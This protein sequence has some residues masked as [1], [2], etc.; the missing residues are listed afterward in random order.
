MLHCK[1]GLFLKVLDRISQSFICVVF[2]VDIHTTLP[3]GRQ[4][5]AIILTLFGEW[6][7]GANGE[8]LDFL[9]G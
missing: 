4:W 1:S 8:G 9:R 2:V 6:D 5:E 7:N 3:T